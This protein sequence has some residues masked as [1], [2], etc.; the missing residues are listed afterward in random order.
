GDG[1]W[2]APSIYGKDIVRFIIDASPPEVL[3]TSP[4]ELSLD[5]DTNIYGT[6]NGDIAGFDKAHIRVST[7]TAVKKYWD[8]TLNEWVASADTWNET[9]KLGSTSWYYT[10][11]GTMLEENKTYTSAARALDYAGNYSTTY[12]TRVFTNSRPSS[13]IDE[14]SGVAYNNLTELSGT[15]EDNIGITEV[16]IA[17]YNYSQGLCY[18]PAYTPQPWIGCSESAAPWTNTQSV[19]EITSATWTYAIENSSWTHNAS[20][21]VKARSKDEAGNWD[22]VLS[23][24]EFTFDTAIPVSTITFPSDGEHFNLADRELT[25]LGTSFDEGIGIED[26]KFYIRRNIDDYYWTGVSWQLASYPLPGL[27]T[28]D[29]DDW[30][31]YQDN[32]SFYIDSEE[33]KIYTWARDWASN[34][35]TMELKATFV[36]DITKPTS[37]IT[38]PYDNGYISQTGKI[39]GDSYDKTHGIVAESFIRIKQLTGPKAGHYWRVVDSSWTIESEPEIWNAVPTYGTLSPDA[40]WWQL[41]TAPWQTGE[42]YEMN[43]YVGDKAGNYETVYST[44]TDIKADFT[45][46]SSTVTYPADG[47]L[48]EVEL[49]V[50]SGSA[51]DFAPGILDKVQVS[52]Y[53]VDNTCSGQYWDRV[54]GAWNSATEIF[55]DADVVG[56]AWTATG[57]STPTW[58]SDVDG[59]D[60]RI[61]AKG[62]DQAGNEVVKPGSTGV[63]SHIQFTLKPPPPISGLIN[64]N[65]SVPHW[66]ANPAPTINGTA[67]DAT[68]VQIKVVDFGPDLIEGAGNDDLC[69]NG[70]AWVSTNTVNDFVGAH[71]FNAPN[72]NWS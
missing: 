28:G 23:T 33:Y 65:L 57:A 22:V 52:Y 54:S 26:I 9:E 38:Y 25:I 43:A 41:N 32:N 58:V 27:P 30:T 39:T 45:A 1:N 21:R 60:Y 66:K 49:T 68:T 31:S 4:T 8:D 14:P 67:T 42:T 72:W 62:I 50:I 59:V 17:I 2:G 7:G 48:V 3:I 15:A 16:Q 20:Y 6:A 24:A 11:D 36:Y 34:E 47:T 13:F 40:T 37:S 71:N 12:S 69:W 46:P 51:S 70:G 63:G 61:F 35:E 19:L 55:Y 64:P 10:V 56:D 44:V 29:W 5:S 18:N 53:C